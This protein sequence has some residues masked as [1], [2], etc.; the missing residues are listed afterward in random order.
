VL[1][2]GNNFFQQARR[3]FVIESY[4]PALTGACSLGERILIHLILNLRDDFNGTPQYKSV[5]RKESFD[6]WDLAIET[7]EAWRV[8]LPEAAENFRKLAR[9]RNRAAVHFNPATDTNERGLAIEALTLLGEIISA[10]FSALGCQ[11]WFLNVPGEM[12]IKKVAESEPF[13]RRVYLPNCCL[14]GPYHEVASITP[15][16]RFVIRDDH[17]YDEREISDEEFVALRR[18][19]L[20]AAASYFKHGL[21]N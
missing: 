15:D 18:V 1:P 3:A 11:P 14:V 9:V 13:V 12:Y 20:V 2:R 4:Y 10:Q 19:L 21:N 7:L 6:N 17:P 5:Y 16:L 8:L